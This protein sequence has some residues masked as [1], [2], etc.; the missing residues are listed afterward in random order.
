MKKLYL[1]AIILLLGIMQVYAQNIPIQVNNV[2]YELDFNQYQEI[3]VG[4]NDTIDI[5]INYSEWAESYR[6][7]W[8]SI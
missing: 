6:F 4:I 7:R 8:T 2:S 5:T 1:S 3:C